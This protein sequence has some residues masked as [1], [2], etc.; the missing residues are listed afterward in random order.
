MNYYAW[1][2]MTQWA[3]NKYPFEMERE[4]LD[5]WSNYVVKW[6]FEKSSIKNLKQLKN[7]S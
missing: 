5:H 7:G 4:Y 3:V 2:Q 1:E 6:D